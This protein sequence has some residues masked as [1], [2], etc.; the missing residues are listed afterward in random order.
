MLERCQTRSCSSRS[1]SGLQTFT[2]RFHRPRSSVFVAAVTSKA[3]PDR[4]RIQ[5]LQAQSLQLAPQQQLASSNLSNRPATNGVHH[6]NKRLKVAVDV[7]E[8]L[9]RFLHSLNKYCLETHGL[10]FDIPDYSDYNFHKIWGCTR[11]ESN[12][13]VHEFFK[14]HHFAVG[15]LPMP[16]ALHSL[17]R[18]NATSDLVIVTSRQHVIQKP[19]L[20]WLELH[21]P[22]IFAEVHFGNHWALEG[23]SKSKSEICRELGAK[24]LIDDNP[25]Y[26]VECANA[27]INVLLYDWHLTYPWSKTADGPSHPLIRRVTD[28][29]EVEEALAMVAQQCQ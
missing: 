13:I 6:S 17:Q 2:A 28:W 14:S 21:Y 29:D 10:N 19:T 27:G 1:A 23:K 22:G 11:D 4:Q 12:H 8:V 9:G 3:S 26:A 5:V 16:G 24:V 25:I 15:V 20:D 7:D 18:L